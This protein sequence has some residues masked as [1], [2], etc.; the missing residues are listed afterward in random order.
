LTVDAATWNRAAGLIGLMALG[1][2]AAVGCAE[3]RPEPNRD[4]GGVLDS[5]THEADSMRQMQE[6]QEQNRASQGGGGMSGGGGG[7]RGY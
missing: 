6:R 1:G 4:L 2:I 3:T 5:R 7:G